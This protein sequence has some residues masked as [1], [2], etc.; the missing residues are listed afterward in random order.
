MEAIHRAARVMGWMGLLLVP[1][2]AWLC[3][4]RAAVGMASGMF[5]ML[6]NVWT[7]TRL[8]RG[9]M[10]PQGAS[11]WT[12]AA[13][14]IVKLPLLYGGGAFLLLSPWSSPLGFLAGFSLWFAALVIG[15]LR[16]GTA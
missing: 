5:W 12:Q 13:L 4:S 11:R 6:A 16:E 14:W 8:V 7:L 2:V 9:S 10:G 3:G 15:A 1:A